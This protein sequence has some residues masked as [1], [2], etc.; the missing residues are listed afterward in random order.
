MSL[1]PV[2]PYAELA[3]IIAIAVALMFCVGL[4]FM[5][6]RAVGKG[7]DAQTIAAKD[8]ALLNASHALEADA[9]LF[10]AIDAESKR[11]IKAADDAKR[12]AQIA[13]AVAVDAERAARADL[14]AYEQ[15]QEKAR[16]KPDCA[17]LL[18]TSLGRMCGL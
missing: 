15:K 1:D 11:R 12:A 5:G 13:E 10:L 8:R 9:S 7:Q 3:K 6:G 18:D 16:K 14:Q 2:K 4:T 17:A